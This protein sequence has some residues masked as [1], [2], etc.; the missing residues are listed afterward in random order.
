MFDILRGNLLDLFSI[1]KRK[2]KI[3]ALGLKKKK[4]VNLI[5]WEK[6]DKIKNFEE[7]EIIFPQIFIKFI[8]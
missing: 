4:S 3:S 5:K 8:L 1:S 7:H 6:K 2:N